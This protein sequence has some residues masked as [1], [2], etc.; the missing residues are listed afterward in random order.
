MIT[1]DNFL[2]IGNLIIN[3]LVGSFWLFVILMIILI[4]YFSVKNNF[5]LKTTLAIIFASSV[6]VA[7][8]YYSSELLVVAALVVGLILYLVMSKLISR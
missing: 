8:Y 1:Q 7:G 6:G 2:D 3:E 5:D 4:L